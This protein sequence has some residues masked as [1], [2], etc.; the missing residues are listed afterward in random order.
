MSTSRYVRKYAQG[1]KFGTPTDRTPDCSLLLWQKARD[2]LRP[3]DKDAISPTFTGKPEDLIVEI[4]TYSSES[5]G[6][7][8]KLP[9]GESFFV[10][11]A[12]EKVSRWVKMFVEVGDTIGQYDPG[13][14][15]L[16]WAFVRLIL[17]VPS[18]DET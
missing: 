7:P 6:K 1:A 13:H 5:R 8:I 16:P 18:A 14:A 11:D 10:R 12:L 2:A 9:N 4:E 3:K 17:Q 15:A